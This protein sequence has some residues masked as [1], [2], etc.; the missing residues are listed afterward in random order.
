MSRLPM[1]KIS[2]VFRQRFELKHSYREV[3]T[4]L[5]I[6]ISTISDYVSRARA[7][8]LSWPLPAGMSEEALHKQL[9]LPVAQTEERPHPEWE[10]VHRE[11]RRKGM[12]LQLLWREYRD[13]VALGLGYSQFCY[14]YRRYAKTL[15]PVMRQL[16]KAGE[17]AFVD[18]AGMTVPWVDVSTGEI[19]EAQ[20]FVG[21]LGASQLIFIEATKTQQLP[22]W[23]DSHIHMFEYFGG[24]PEILVPDNLKSG[25]T[26]A[27][28]YDP[29]INFNYQHFS[30]YY[31]VA[32]VPARAAE[33]KDKAKVENAVGI[34]ERQ[35]LAVLRH[36]TFTSVAGI[37][38]V[39]K[40]RLETLNNQNFQ[41][42]KT[43]RKALFEK[44]DRPALRALPPDRYHYADWK[45]AKI[46]TDY[47]FSFDNHYYSVPYKYLQQ[48]VDIRATNTTV[49]CFYQHTLIAAHTR[50]YKPYSFTTLSE[51]MPTAHQEHAK[52]SP[53]YILHMAKIVGEH[54]LNFCKYM[55]ASRPFPQQ[56]Y[57]ACYG[58]LRL[59]KRFGNDRLEKACA[60][61]LLV[62]SSR[63]Q[64]VEAILKNQLE[65]VPFKETKN[66]EISAHDNI[67][68][69]HYY[70]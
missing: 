30:E 23:I 57:R 55:M 3:A 65:E 28:R 39:L 60:K 5:G 59:G 11:L 48:S 22:E 4:S 63:Y 38:E 41:K 20:I 69:A 29:D 33:P 31:S 6:S 12:T 67:R 49:E 32:I 52:Y 42:M 54:T 19:H 37:N 46:N 15:A 35:I 50:S 45:K 34:V 66:T 68:G 25:V 9:F 51:H 8:G 1:R 21:C 36:H 27:H 16:H 26:K 2:E 13:Q 62:G 56:A 61:A 43:S 24:V 47:H 44:I 70:Q 18:Y 17:K 14:H 64:H 58:L 53:T 10:K 40:P 7:A